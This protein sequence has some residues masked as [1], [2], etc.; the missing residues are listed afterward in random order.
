MRIAVVVTLAVVAG[1]VPK[2]G[3]VLPVP[4]AEPGRVTLAARAVDRVGGVQPIAVVI[5]NGEEHP[6]RVDARQVYA[7]TGDGA[8]FAALPPGEAAR[9][10]GGSHLPGAVKGGIVGAATGSALGALGGAISGAIQGGIGAAVGIGSAVGAA[11]GA[12]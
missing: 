4:P 5:T 10:A 12:V 6:V 7:L 2:H 9:Q 8:R 3:P 11:V 1:C